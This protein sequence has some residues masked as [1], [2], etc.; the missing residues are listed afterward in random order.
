MIRQE[1]I[2]NRKYLEV[3]L[4]EAPETD[5]EWQ[6]NESVDSDGITDEG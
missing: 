1:E 4:H 2:G 6:F 5:G 3:E